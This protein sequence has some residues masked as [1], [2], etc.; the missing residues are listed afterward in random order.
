MRIA[1]AAILS[2]FVEAQRVSEPAQRSSVPAVS[3][4]M[5]NFYEPMPLD[6]FL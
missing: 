2:A 3:Q 6:N 5:W 4:S 1:V